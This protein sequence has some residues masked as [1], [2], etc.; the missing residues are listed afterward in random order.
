M[1]A[2]IN[3]F[4]LGLVIVFSILNYFN[5]G[6]IF[7]ILQGNAEGVSQFVS[8]YS[9]VGKIALTI[10]LVL[11][12]VVVGVFPAV[13]VY[14]IIGLMMGPYWGILLIS[15]GNLVGNS[16]NYL[17]GRII[18]NGFVTNEKYKHLIEKLEGGGLK[19]LLIL[20][21]N[22]VTSIDSIS[23]FAGAL[24]MDYRKFLW[25]T[26]IGVT[27]LIV[28]ATL[29]GTDL[30]LRFDSALSWLL[31]FIGLSAV[32]VIGRKLWE[33]RKNGKSS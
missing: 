26:F 27:P 3:V 6:L 8:S 33:Y 1:L 31:G 13:A 28:G 4:A 30:L 32:V 9:L 22:P 20:R 25:A 21:L 24:G 11:L 10:G 29:F 17:Q 19:E 16:I 18:A 12:E 15:V 14:P 2:S 23:Y 5:E 7:V